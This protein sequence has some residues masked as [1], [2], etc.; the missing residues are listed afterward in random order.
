MSDSSGELREKQIKKQTFS[1]F[2]S[3][4]IIAIDVS[5]DKEQKNYNCD[6][7]LKVKVATMKRPRRRSFIEIENQLLTKTMNEAA[8]T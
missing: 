4:V 5:F 8:P 7:R 6:R 2:R 1:W 3:D